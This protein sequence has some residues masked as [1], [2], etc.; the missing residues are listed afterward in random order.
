MT[1]R[2][3]P[4]RRPEVRSSEPSLIEAFESHPRGAM[5]MAAAQFAEDVS[6]ALRAALAREG[7]Q[8]NELADRVG[9]TAGRV[10]QVLSEGNLKVS[11]I[12][13]FARALGYQ[14]KLVLDRVEGDHDRIAVD[15]GRLTVRSSW[16]AVQL[17][18]QLM[19]VLPVDGSV[20]VRTVHLTNSASGKGQPAFSAFT[21]VG[22]PGRRQSENA[23][24]DRVS[25]GPAT[26]IAAGRVKV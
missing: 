7:I 11:T 13:K 15:A 24:Q 2:E 20:P 16:S 5:E 10:S 12:G 26:T 18:D 8:R 9:V 23:K 1:P 25:L 14:A 3:R 17:D 22:G 21:A 19:L 4:A 6:I